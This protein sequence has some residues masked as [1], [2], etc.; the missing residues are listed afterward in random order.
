MRQRERDAVLVIRERDL[1]RHRLEFFT[2]I[3][4]GNTMTGK[5]QHAHIILCITERHDLMLID[6][7]TAA[8]LGK[9]T[10]LTD[11]LDRCLIEPG[12]R[13]HEGQLLLKPAA[14]V[15]ET[16][17]QDLIRCCRQDL[18]GAKAPCFHCI[19]N[20]FDNL[21]LE[22]IVAALVLHLMATGIRCENELP[23]IDNRGEFRIGFEMTQ[24]AQRCV[25]FK[26]A[27]KQDFSCRRI[28]DAPTVIRKQQSMMILE[29][30]CFCFPAQ[31]GA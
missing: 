24:E 13:L 23:V 27:V 25:S 12:C 21:D 15:C 20:I 14:D 22:I 18:D 28:L 19:C 1:I 7:E 26:T 2:G 17:H 4:H 6:A 16:R 3:P 9:R 5:F 29:T 31:S 30:K 8:D 11:S 10:R